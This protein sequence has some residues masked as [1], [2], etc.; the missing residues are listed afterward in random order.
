MVCRVGAIPLLLVGLHLN[1]CAQ[2]LESDKQRTSYAVGNVM[3][4]ILQ[5]GKDELDWDSFVRGLRD[6]MDG[7]ESPISKD[8]VQKLV[9]VF[10]QTVQQ[11]QTAALQAEGKNWLAENAKREGVVTLP[12]GLQYKVIRDGTGKTPTESDQ[13][14]AHYRGTFIDGKEFDSSYKRGEPTTFPVRGVIPGWTEAL[15]LMKEGA[16]WELYIP[17]NLAYGAR[18][19]QGIPPFSTLLFEIELVQVVAAP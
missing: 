6:R 1:V 2:E 18:G 19:R 13:V 5:Q 7:K 10:Q 11:K 15:L 12:S 4:E 8:D 17:F 14:M 16:K 9:A 3:G